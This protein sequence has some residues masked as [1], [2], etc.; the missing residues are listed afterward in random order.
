MRPDR[1][2]RASL[3]IRLLA[4][5]GILM[6]MV[7]I[8]IPG[9]RQQRREQSRQRV[10]DSLVLLSLAKEAYAVE[11][12][13][14]PGREVTLDQVLTETQ[15]ISTAPPLRPDDLELNPVGEPPAYRLQNGDVLTP[16]A[17]RRAPA[18]WESPR[19]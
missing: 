5:G 17:A 10:V 4:I 7:L 1:S 11:H 8:S 14:P 19:Y 6:L 12:D 13:L 15:Y 2:P 9:Y 3:L 16:R 18:S